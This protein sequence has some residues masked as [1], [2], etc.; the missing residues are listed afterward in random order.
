MTPARKKPVDL[1]EAC[2]REA[3]AIVEREGV[4]RLS[5]REVARRL[6]VS[7]QAPYK[8]YDSRDHLLA[9]LVARAFDAFARHLDALPATG[10][11]DRD[12]G[13]MG[14]AYLAYAEA[15]PLQY[16]LMFGTPLPDP[17]A[18]PEM[19]RTARHAFTRLSEGLERLRAAQGKPV[20]H[21]ATHLD[22]L[23]IWATLHGYAAIAR[24]RIVGSLGL[25]PAVLA[26]G[27]EHLLLRIGTGIHGVG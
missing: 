12:L 14:H 26:R 13:Q 3:L 15:H 9:E 17:D 2:V 22:A 23:F 18:H 27:E 1:R 24:S 8:H 19:M 21:D 6:G 25:P 11:A 5:L 20:D 16:R 10:H 7:H 4:E